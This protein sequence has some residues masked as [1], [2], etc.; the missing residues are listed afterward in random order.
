MA[1]RVEVSPEALANLDAIARYIR[2]RGTFES[3]ERWFNETIDAIRSLGELP[4][5][6]PL[7]EESEDFQT[8]FA[9]FLT[10]SVIAAITSI[11]PLSPQNR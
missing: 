8:E 2:K 11:S 3:A 1:L 5:R 6:C 4:R 9:F 7:T 10:A